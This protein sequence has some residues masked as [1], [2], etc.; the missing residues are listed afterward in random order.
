MEH[1][2]STNSERLGRL[3]LRSP[4]VLTTESLSDF[5]R[6]SH[7]SFLTSPHRVKIAYQDER[8]C[9]RQQ[10]NV[11]RLLEAVQTTISVDHAASFSSSC[12]KPTTPGNNDSEDVGAPA[13]TPPSSCSSSSSSSSHSPTSVLL[14]KKA[15]RYRNMLDRAQQVDLNDPAFDV[16]LFLGVEWC[17]V[18]R[19]RQAES[20]QQDEVREG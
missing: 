12:I 2:S 15:L 1:A 18:D 5:D 6:T 4:A 13:A 8:L 3:V 7:A 19:N 16:G 10:A 9:R 17:R 20:A 11:V 14:A